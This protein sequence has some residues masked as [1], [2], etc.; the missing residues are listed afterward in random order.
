LCVDLDAVAFG[1]R[2]PQ[3]PPVLGERLI[4]RLRAQ[5]VQ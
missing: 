2:P 3:Q 5:F 1:E 4:V